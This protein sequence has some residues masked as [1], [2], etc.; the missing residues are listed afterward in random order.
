M[1]SVRRFLLICGACAAATALLLGLL[2]LWAVSVDYYPVVPAE[3]FSLGRK[4]GAVIEG[5][6]LGAVLGLA[7][8][9]A[10]SLLALGWEAMQSGDRA[11]PT[12]AAPPLGL[13]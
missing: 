8:G 10:V 3:G 2:F 9:V 4:V 11:T 13:L 1:V 5:A 7:V 6:A 12:P